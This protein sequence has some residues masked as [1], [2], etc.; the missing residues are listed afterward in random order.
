MRGTL[1]GGQLTAQARFKIRL[2][3][4][5]LFGVLPLTPQDTCQTRSATV[6]QLSSPEGFDALRGGRLTGRYAISDLT[7][8]GLLEPF[9]NPLTKGGGNTLDLALTTRAGAV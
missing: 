1:T 8:C 6:A 5:Y 4:L 2:P 3:Q 9:L 7:G